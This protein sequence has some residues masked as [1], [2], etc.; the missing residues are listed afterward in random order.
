M[1]SRVAEVSVLRRL[2]AAAS[3][4][5][6]AV[7]LWQLE[8][9]R[10]GLAI[11]PLDVEGT[12]ATVYRQPDASGPAVIIAHG[13]AGS[14]QLMEA[15]ALTLARAG[16]VA[17]SFD[18]QGHG[19]NRQPMSGD[20]TRIDGTTRYLVAETAA[21]IDAAL[22]LR[23]VTGPVALLGHSMA[24][25][26]L[27]R[28]ARADPRVAAVVAVSM[29][30][31]AVTGTEPGRLL[32]VTGEW[33][34]RLRA[35][36]LDAMRLVD[37]AA[38]EGETVSDPRGATVRRA[39]VA[40]MVE[41]V[42]VLY[43]PTSLAE[44]RAWLD[45]AF[46][47][48]SVGP[49]TAT[50][51]WIVLLLAGI[52]ALA[53]PLSALLPRRAGRPAAPDVATFLAAVCVPAAATP[54]LLYPVD[55]R[56]LPVLVADYLALHLLVYGAVMLAVLRFRGVRFGPYPLLPI[57]VLVAYGLAAFG[58]ALDRYAASF[59]PHADR[60][61]IVL[62]LGCGAVPFM[63]AD[64]LVTEGGGAR[65]WRR[66][67]ARAGFLASL[68]I[69]VALDFE[70]LFFLVMILPVIVLFFLTFGTMGRWVGRRTGAPAA[71][72]TGLGVLLAW[73]LG[74]SFPLVAV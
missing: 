65:L 50:G 73:A 70:R 55:T 61:P 3:F 8:S 46:G 36:A 39:V 30:S 43:S 22:A 17:V 63:L 58:L 56:V 52:V 26:I 72:G 33:E 44:A 10:S 11:T 48:E 34:R 24:T 31:E 23:G 2:V 62:A 69:A 6:I 37:P 19:R 20:V 67:A 45:R 14:R 38:E 1:A 74:V 28:H 21:V 53:W 32:I 35:A 60:I 18:F 68:G 9:A 16:Y 49:V 59:L 42:G 7:S 57:L 71:A 15:F 5:L 47:R 51:V 29:Y 41:H 4:L 12:P 27:V 25:D 54:L 13:F 40:P 64:G 66:A